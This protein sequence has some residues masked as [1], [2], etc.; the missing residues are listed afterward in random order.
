VATGTAEARKLLSVKMMSPLAERGMYVCM[1][2]M[3]PL[4][5][6]GDHRDSRHQKPIVAGRSL[7]R[8]WQVGDQ[9]RDWPS[10]PKAG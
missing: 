7:K 2:P 6:V 5:G 4:A 10:L 9:F 3:P 1:S 8:T